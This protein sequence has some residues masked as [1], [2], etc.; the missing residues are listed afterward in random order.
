MAN[1]LLANVNFKPC[2][3]FLKSIVSILKISGCSKH[4]Q[5]NKVV[6]QYF[7]RK[8]KCGNIFCIKKIQELIAPH[9]FST[10]RQCF[11]YNMFEN[12]MPR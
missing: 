10:K 7:M 3:E 5:L 2:P 6:S 1:L 4:C 9:N 11:A 8:I 12:L